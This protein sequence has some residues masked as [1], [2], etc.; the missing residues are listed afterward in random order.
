MA[1]RFWVPGP[2]PGMNEIIKAAKAG[3]R[4]IV[5]S[6]MKAE[7]TGHVEMHARSARVPPCVRVRLDLLWVEAKK[8]NGANRDPDN[9]EAGA[10]FVWDGLVDAGVIPNDKAENNAGSSH[11]HERGPC[12]GVWVTV[13]PA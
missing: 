9:I 3:R 4:G 13:V 12:P 6:N 8:K 10:K 5:Y 1:S 7:W 2:L 11:H